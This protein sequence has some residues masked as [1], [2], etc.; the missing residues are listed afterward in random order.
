MTW[1]SVDNAT[2]RFVLASLAIR[3]RF[4]DRF[5]RLKVLSHVSR[6]RF[7]PHGTPLSSIGSRWVRFPD[8]RGRIDVLRLPVTAVR[9][10]ICFASGVHATLLG[11]CLAACACAPGC[12]AGRVNAQPATQLPAYSYVDVSGISQVPRRSILCLCLSPRPR[13]NRRSLA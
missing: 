3:C 9:S 4:V 13:P 6:Q 1:C 2:P 12:L 8:V 7:S 5:V 10:L 11:S